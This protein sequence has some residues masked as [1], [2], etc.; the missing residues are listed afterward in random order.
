MARRLFLRMANL[1]LMPCS[2]VG[3]GVAAAVACCIKASQQ[4]GSNND[5]VSC[6]PKTSDVLA[7]KQQLKQAEQCLTEIQYSPFAHQQV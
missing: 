1:L 6:L 4:R 7:D 2:E 3:L 5:G